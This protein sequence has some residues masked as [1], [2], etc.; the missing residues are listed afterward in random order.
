[1]ISLYVLQALFEVDF[2]HYVLNSVF[3]S[4]SFVASF[5][6]C[7]RRATALM[8][9]FLYLLAAVAVNGA[10]SGLSS[11]SERESSSGTSVDPATI[12]TS[13]FVT[14]AG[15][16]RRSLNFARYNSAPVIS[17]YIIQTI[18]PYSFVGC[19]TESTVWRALRGK[20]YSSDSMSLEICATTCAGF[21]WFGVE[22]AR[23]CRLIFRGDA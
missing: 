13:P 5:P 2:S 17:P 15:Y 1:V 11:L 12:S 19:Y 6:R 3:T 20:S 23:E 10:P 21:K 4:I 8:R 22:Y 7:S 9:L 16:V 14:F 18:G